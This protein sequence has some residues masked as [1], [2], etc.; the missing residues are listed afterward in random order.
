MSCQNEV[1][2][3]TMYEVIGEIGSGTYGTVCKAKLEGTS[4]IF[5][6]KKMKLDNDGDMSYSTIRET[7]AIQRLD[8]PNILKPIGFHMTIDTMYMVMPYVK[9]K[10]RIYT[11]MLVK[12]MMYRLLLAELHMQVNHI[13]HRDLKPDNI[14]IDGDIPIIIDFSIASIDRTDRTDTDVITMWWRTPELFRSWYTPYDNRIDVWSLGVVMFT[15]L[16]G[17]ILFYGNTEYEYLSNVLSVYSDGKMWLEKYIDNNM[18]LVDP[19]KIKIRNNISLDRVL[20]KAGIGEAERELIMYMIPLYY[21][22][23]PTPLDVLNHHYFDDIRSSEDIDEAMKIVQPPYPYP[24]ISGMNIRKRYILTEWMLEVGKNVGLDL[25]TIASSIMIFDRYTKA[26][27]NGYKGTIIIPDSKITPGV[28]PPS[29]EW[30]ILGVAS[31][32]LA[33]LLY[34]YRVPTIEYLIDVSMEDT[35]IGREHLSLYTKSIY[36]ALGYQPSSYIPELS[37]AYLYDLIIGHILTSDTPSYSTIPPRI[38][39]MLSVLP[40]IKV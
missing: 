2:A 6:I 40:A 4:Q 32:Y 22:N 33:I 21:S 38:E 5:A 26:I 36:Q 27:A 28:F 37:H 19:D 39:K 9:D 20:A 8:H 11:P 17:E 14:L 3:D 25:I 13:I 23:I 24:M 30:Q 1:I 16:T 31:L 7:T 29:D 35:V 18:L 12:Y 34:Q 15:L 10:S